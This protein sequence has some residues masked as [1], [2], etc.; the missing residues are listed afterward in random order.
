MPDSIK[1]LKEAEDKARELAETFADRAKRGYAGNAS[2]AQNGIA[3]A[4]LLK[5]YAAL[6]A[7]R[8]IEEEAANIEHKRARKGPNTSKQP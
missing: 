3:S 2:T 6:R 5:A 4:E 8:F 1:E 7:Q